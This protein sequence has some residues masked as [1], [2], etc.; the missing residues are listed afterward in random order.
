MLIKGKYTTAQVYT[1]KNVE[2][3]IEDYAASQIQALCDQPINEGCQI[4]VMPD[5]HAESLGQLDILRLSA[6]RSCRMWS[7]LI[8]AAG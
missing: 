2:T 5:V 4:A 3:A 8:S 1:T 6:K 7:G